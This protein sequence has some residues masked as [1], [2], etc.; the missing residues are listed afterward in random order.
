MRVGQVPAQ[1][2]CHHIA[3]IAGSLID[4]IGPDPARPTERD[5]FGG[6]QVVAGQLSG[7]REMQ[8]QAIIFVY[9]RDSSWFGY[10]GRR[11]EPHP[12]NPCPV[13]PGRR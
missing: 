7:K 8:I 6:I 3:F 5:F 1:L 4:R 10:N 2:A 12:A 9:G 13:V 11:C